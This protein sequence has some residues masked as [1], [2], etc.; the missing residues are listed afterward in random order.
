M[1]VGLWHKLSVFCTGSNTN[2]SVTSYYKLSNEE[3]TPR[4]W[5]SGDLFLLPYYTDIKVRCKMKWKTVCLCTYRCCS[6]SVLDCQ[7]KNDALANGKHTMLITLREQCVNEHHQCGRKLAVAKLWWL[8]A[9]D[10]K[11]G[12]FQT[13]LTL[14]HG[15][16]VTSGLVP[17][18]QVGSCSVT[19]S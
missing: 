7:I 13:K 8:N 5:W 11:K 2:N 1:P 4:V 14:A 6:C 15:N 3:Y 12:W 17:C 16:Y 9:P 18:V 19:S 10:G